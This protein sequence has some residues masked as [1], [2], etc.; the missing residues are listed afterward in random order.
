MIQMAK[1][2]LRSF[3]K[4]KIKTIPISEMEKQGEWRGRITKPF[5]SSG[6]II[7]EMV[8]NTPA[9]RNCSRVFL[10]VNLPSEVP[11]TA[12]I[13]RALNDSKKC[14][15]P[16]VTETGLKMLRVY[17]QSDLNQFPTTIFPKFTLT[18]PSPDYNGTTR[19]DR[20]PENGDLLIVPGLAFDTSGNRIGRG[21]G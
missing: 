7:K 4:K 12:M 11:T 9:Y 10:F 6:E 15:V 17:S 2:E 20:I 13:F 5:I 19:E 1:A 16:K 18:E 14:Y 21:K 8:T 3:M